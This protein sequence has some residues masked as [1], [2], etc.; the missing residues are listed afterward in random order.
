MNVNGLASWQSEKLGSHLLR[1]LSIGIL[2]MGLCFNPLLQPGYA[3]SVQA[4][5]QQA[6]ASY[7]QMLPALQVKLRN[8]DPDHLPDFGDLVEASLI[9]DYQLRKWHL[10]V[11]TIFK[12]KIE[13]STSAYYSGGA[14]SGILDYNEPQGRYH[15]PDNSIFKVKIANAY[16]RLSLYMAQYIYLDVIEADLP[17]G[18]NL[19]FSSRRK[20]QDLANYKYYYSPS[21]KLRQFKD[22]ILF[23]LG[24]KHL[25]W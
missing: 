14:F 19:K 3:Q 12:G 6:E 7:Y 15:F 20:A 9:D 11:G 22:S 17:S 2:T 21:A 18:E 5:P 4:K 25:E 1:L 10:P 13:C 24:V 23:L 8:I 16:G